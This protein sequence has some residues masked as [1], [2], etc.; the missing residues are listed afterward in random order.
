MIGPLPRGGGCL[1]LFKWVYGLSTLYTLYMR[2]GGVIV[3]DKL[4]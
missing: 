3:L 1:S 4:V 2:G